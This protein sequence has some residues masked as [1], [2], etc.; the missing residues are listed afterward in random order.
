M[1]YYNVYED[2][3]MILE[4]VSR[5]EIEDAI[6]CKIH[7]VGSH[8]ESGH[9]VAGKYTLSYSDKSDSLIDFPD[10]WEMAIA[11]FKNVEWS[12]RE[13]KKLNIM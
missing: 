9:K 12:R 4:N 3:N 8:I 5:K 6:G 2:G 11:P 7:N 1:N 10:K 13:G